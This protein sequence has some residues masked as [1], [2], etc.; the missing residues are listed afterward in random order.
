MK[1]PKDIVSYNDF[2]KVKESMSSFK[3]VH[4]KD[5]KVF[6]KLLEKAIKIYEKRIYDFRAI[7]T[8]IENEMRE[9]NH[10]MEMKYKED[11]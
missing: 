4:T 5:N 6:I 11:D 10:R 9:H 8:K 3:D 1:E 7:I 2:E